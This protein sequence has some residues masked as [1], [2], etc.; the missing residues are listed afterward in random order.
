MTASSS[1]SQG[2][3]KRSRCISR[4]CKHIMSPATPTSLGR[5]RA[6]LTR[7]LVLRSAVA[8]HGTQ[9]PVA[10]PQ[11]STVGRRASAACRVHTHAAV[12][13]RHARGH[14]YDHWHMPH[15]TPLSHVQIIH[16]TTFTVL[17]TSG[18]S[19]LASLVCRHGSSRRYEHALTMVLRCVRC[20][21][22]TQ[23]NNLKD[24]CLLRTSSVLVP[25]G[26]RERD[27]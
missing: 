16:A 6:S 15:N 24:V 11:G 18:Q 14:G 25:Y 4:A 9:Y 23:H 3:G 13:W 12:V 27:G 19:H 7:Q 26:S 22:P 17:Q 10:R 2:G 20:V 8:P 5:A 21:P 1:S